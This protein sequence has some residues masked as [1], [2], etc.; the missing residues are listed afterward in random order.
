MLLAEQYGAG[1]VSVIYQGYLDIIHFAFYP[2]PLQLR[3]LKLTILFNYEKF[4]FAVSS[5]I[6]K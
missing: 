4:I 3:E 5:R 6:P 2:E 1:Q